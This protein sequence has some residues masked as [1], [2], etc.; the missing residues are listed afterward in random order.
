MFALFSKTDEGLIE[1][2]ARKKHEFEISQK[3]N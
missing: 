1:G 3:S 2:T